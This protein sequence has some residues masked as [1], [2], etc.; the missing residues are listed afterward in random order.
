MASVQ[1]TTT[2]SAAQAREEQRSRGGLPDRDD[3][4]RGLALTNLLDLKTDFAY[5]NPDLR[6]EAIS[7]EPTRLDEPD[8]IAGSAT[9]KAD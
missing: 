3:A 7:L 5:W 6:V 2:I 4:L 8:G 1:E 9:G